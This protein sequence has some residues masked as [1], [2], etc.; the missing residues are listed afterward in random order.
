MSF[1]SEMIAAFIMGLVGAGH[2]LAMCGGMASVFSLSFHHQD[3]KNSRVFSDKFYLLLF[4]NSG[5]I[6]SYSLLGALVAGFS[7]GLIQVSNFSQ[8]FVFL[9]IIAAIMI[10]LS[11]FYIARLWNG[12]SYIEKAGQIIWKQIAPFTSHFLP[13]KKVTT[14]FP[15]GFLW[16]WLPCGLV[17]TALTWA[18][19]SGSAQQGLLIMMAF[20]VGTLPVTLAI[21]SVAN[22]LKKTLNNMI[23]RY[24]S[25]LL[26][27]IYGIFSLHLAYNQL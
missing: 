22:K 16:G 26:L 14:A 25:S 3:T 9:R 1:Y 20:G 6:V 8:G 7:A 18:S 12:L 24:F 5:R 2:C 21:G 11:A 17:Y 19:V 23:F 4:Y 27:L 10:L 15:L 13:L